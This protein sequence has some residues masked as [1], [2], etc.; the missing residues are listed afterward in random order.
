MTSALRAIAFLPYG[1]LMDLWRWDIF[2][3]KIKPNEYNRKWWEMRLKYQGILPPG[4]ISEEN[5]DA[6][7]KFHIAWDVPYI[8]LVLGGFTRL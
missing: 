5:L 7:A 3:G 4:E 2:S 1:A 8:R 6:A